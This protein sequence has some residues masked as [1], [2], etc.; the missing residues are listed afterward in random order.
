ML[1]KDPRRGAGKGGEGRTRGFGHGL[2]LALVV[3][4]DCKRL[5]R[6]GKTR[7]VVFICRRRNRLLFQPFWSDVI[8]F[9]S[10]LLLLFFSIFVYC[11]GEDDKYGEGSNDRGLCF[12]ADLRAGH[13]V[14][15]ESLVLSSMDF[16]FPCGQSLD[17]TVILHR[18][19]RP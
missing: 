1:R 18:K 9:S 19:R 11:D 4:L 8:F 5:D 6:Q 17:S 2:Q 7:H 3:Q 15:S 16:C 12:T 13:E 14:V 10:S